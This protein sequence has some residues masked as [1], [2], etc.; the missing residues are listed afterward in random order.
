M[1]GRI[2]Y[3]VYQVSGI[4]FDGNYDS[5]IIFVVILF[6]FDLVGKFRVCIF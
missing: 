4:I 5:I 1:E 3:G 6:F 2:G